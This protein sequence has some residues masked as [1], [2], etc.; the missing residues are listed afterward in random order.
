MLVVHGS[1][2]ETQGIQGA[3]RTNKCFTTRRDA[4]A[5]PA[6]DLLEGNFSAIPPN[7]KWVADFTHC[8][9]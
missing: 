8:A 6:P 9:T 1:V 3:S 2:L 5:V 7:E 4:A